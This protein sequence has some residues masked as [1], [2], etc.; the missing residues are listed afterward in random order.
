MPNDTPNPAADT[1]L[2]TDARDDDNAAAVLEQEGSDRS[3]GGGGLFGEDGPAGA[4][5]A[6]GGTAPNAPIDVPLPA[7]ARD[8]GADP[9]ADAEARVRSSD[10]A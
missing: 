8:G 5:A 9:S 4:T 6:P 1:P 7:A 3:P 10:D 2:P